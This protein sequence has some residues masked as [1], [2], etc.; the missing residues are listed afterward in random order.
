MTLAAYKPE[1]GKSILRSIDAISQ[2]LNTI[3]TEQYQMKLDGKDISGNYLLLEVM[4]TPAFGPRI[5]ANPDADTGDG[6]FEVV[7]I[8]EDERSGVLDY[9]KGLLKEELEELPN[10]EVTRGRKL[11]ISWNGYPFHVDAEVRPP[12][13]ELPQDDGERSRSITDY[14]EGKLC[15]EIIPKALEF[16]VPEIEPD[17]QNNDQ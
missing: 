11:E 3:Q 8:R 10:V 5:N 12:G 9:L 1:R 4:N 2:T 14:D 13:Y 7:R 17:G 16:L 6:M 15:I